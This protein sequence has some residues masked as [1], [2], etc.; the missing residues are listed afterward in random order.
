[1]FWYVTFKNNVAVFVNSC[2]GNLQ[3]I[4]VRDA[5][6][7]NFSYNAVVNSVIFERIKREQS[8]EIGFFEFV[9]QILELLRATELGQK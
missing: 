1:M 3:R 8:L 2:N 7:Y 9:P 6:D 5:N 4:K